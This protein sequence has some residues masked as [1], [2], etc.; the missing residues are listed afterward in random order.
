LRLP[1]VRQDYDFTGLKVINER[2]AYS[3]FLK[4]KNKLKLL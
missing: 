3:N 4:I 1:D 2:W